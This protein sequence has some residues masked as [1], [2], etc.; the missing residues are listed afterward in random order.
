VANHG[1]ASLSIFKR[2]N[3]L[4]AG[5]KLRYGPRPISVLKDPRLR[6]PHSVAFTP[7]G[8]HFAVTN[9]G[10]DFVA[11]YQIRSSYLG[12]RLEAQPVSQTVVTDEQI[13]RDVNSLN[14]MEGGP[15]GIAIHESEM[16]VCSPEFGLKIYS[17][18]AREGVTA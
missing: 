10:A 1:N 13:F 12:T 5:G 18:R 15:K 14:K 4:L 3:K 16:A 2:R 11:I 9:A 6:Y 17:Y 8:S 7:S